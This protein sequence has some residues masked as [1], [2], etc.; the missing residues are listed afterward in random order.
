MTTITIERTILDRLIEAWDSTVLPTHRDGMM[1]ERMEDLRAELAKPAKASQTASQLAA[2]VLSDCGISTDCTA[3]LMV[4]EARIAQHEEEMI[5]SLQKLAKP[6][7]H[8]ETITTDIAVKRLC[9]ALR[10]D[11]DYAWS[12]HCN[13]AMTAYDAGCPHDV[14]NEG[15]ARFMQLLADV[16][17]REHFAFEG[18][19]AKSKPVEP[20][21]AVAWLDDFGNVFP[22]GARKGAESWIESWI[23]AN[24]RNWKPLYLHPPTPA[25]H[26]APEVAALKSEIERLRKDAERL[27]YIEESGNFGVTRYRSGP[28]G[29]VLIEAE[30]GKKDI[31]KSASSL[32]DAIDS[33]IKEAK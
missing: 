4:V 29:P 8:V 16:D 7:E 21:T 24:Q 31:S 27:D 14:A 15:A 30:D 6:V 22:I 2:T 12:W 10:D 28:G 13:V 1:Q 11:L 23:A 33:V 25:W 19:Q 18:T 9:K 32:R 3:L 20:V 5:D 17:T 26:D